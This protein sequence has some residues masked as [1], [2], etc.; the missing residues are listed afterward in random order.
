MKDLMHSMEPTL[1]ELLRVIR[2]EP[3]LSTELVT[4]RLKL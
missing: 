3:N 1:R 2:R 4:K